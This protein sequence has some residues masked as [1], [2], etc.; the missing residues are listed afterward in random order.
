MGRIRLGTFGKTKQRRF[1]ERL[2]ETCNV[3]VAARA[4]EVAVSTCYRARAIDL[5]FAGEWDA[6]LSVG[7]ARL[8]AALLDYALVKVECGQADPEAIAPEEI[9]GSVRTALQERNVNHGDLQVALRILA[10]HRAASDGQKARDGAAEPSEAEIDT[11]LR[12]AL[13]GLARRMKTA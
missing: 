12:R 9:P 6:A 13:D 11:M 10:H 7:Y 8:E 3:S 1:L 2:A 5:V 4:C